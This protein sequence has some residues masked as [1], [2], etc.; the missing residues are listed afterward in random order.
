MTTELL[1]IVVV[2]FSFGTCIHTY[3]RIKYWHWN[4]FWIGENPYFIENTFYISRFYNIC[5]NKIHTYLKTP[6]VVMQPTLYISAYLVSVPNT[7]AQ[8]PGLLSV[9][10]ANMYTYKH[11]FLC[12]FY[13]CTTR[14]IYEEQQEIWLISE[15]CILCIDRS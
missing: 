14:N 5:N 10:T 13:Y 3:V 8:R 15:T 6:P 11:S 1:Y 7:M 2:I 4:R 12:E 9:R